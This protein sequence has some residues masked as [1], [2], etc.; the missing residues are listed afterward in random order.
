MAAAA[1][2]AGALRYRA[3]LSYSHTDSR[4]AAQLHRAVE[5]YVIPKKL[6]G[7]TGLYGPL[8]ARLTPLFR[9][10]DELSTAAELGSAIEAALGDSEALIV[11]CSPAAAQSRWVN[12]EIR[13]FKMLGREARIYP[14]ILSGEPGSQD[15]AS[16]CFPSALLQRFAADGA[17][18]PG[19]AEPMAADAR[20]S[21]DGRKDAQLKLIAGLLGIGFDALKQRE[22]ARRQNRLIAIAVAATAMSA[23]FAASTIYAL[24]QQRE[25]ERQRQRAEQETAT[26]EQTADFM[27][28]LFRIADPSESRGNSITA[29]EILDKGVAQINMQLSRQ[30]AV[31]ADML[32]TMGEV[33]TSLGL[34]DRAHTLL[35]TADQNFTTAKSMSSKRSGSAIALAEADYYRSDYD[36][37][38]KK[39]RQTLDRL[40]DDTDKDKLLRYRAR[41][42]LG[43]VYLAAE[44]L[45]E[46]EALFKRL[47][48]EPKLESVRGADLRGYAL[49][50]YGQALYYQDKFD[51]GRNSLESALKYRQNLSGPN[52]PQAMI[53]YNELGALEYFN[54]NLDAAENWFSQ[55]VLATARVL[56]ESHPVYA[57]TLNNLARIKLMRRKI[58]EA[59]PMLEQVVSIQDKLL[60]EKHDQIVFSLNSLGMVRLAQGRFAEADILFRRALPVAT[61]RLPAMQGAVM[62]NLAD[63]QCRSGKLESG[64]T[65]AR[66]ALAHMQSA[67]KDEAWQAAWADSVLA[68]CEAKAGGKRAALRARQQAALAVLTK[69]WGAG[70]YYVVDAEN[71]LKALN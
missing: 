9:D 28:S 27:K 69:R 36:A 31:K 33:Y 23:V 6:V 53:L 20:A 57:S 59:A 55:A 40:N 32:T 61:A 12:E 44:K 17:L 11:L 10:R 71:R 58:Y 48:D 5:A 62:V 43:E 14:L 63:T 34:Y 21:G 1:L 42:R 24:Q 49:T 50:G 2:S 66:A 45:P 60:G 51:N 29:R 8:P 56:N 30:P 3:F 52:H 13:R 41:V 18:V 64:T 4:F 47:V 7:I 70:N 67:H 22:L 35:I 19:T 16:A 38:E 37:A 54:E 46:A 26:A 15:P 65:E 39:L 25:A 68:A